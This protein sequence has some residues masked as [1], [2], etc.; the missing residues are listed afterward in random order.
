[1][2]H[3]VLSKL[4][5]SLRVKLTYDNKLSTT[6]RIKTMSTLKHKDY[7]PYPYSNGTY[8]VREIY[9]SVRGGDTIGAGHKLTQRWEVYLN[10][11]PKSEPDIII[12]VTEARD[13]DELQRI[14]PGRIEQC[15][16][17]DVSKNGI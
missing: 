15:L 17:G 2:P 9:I 10:H 13:L 16:A 4:S 8:Y 14:V 6:T 11:P 5:G 3:A 1:L 12:D 7:D